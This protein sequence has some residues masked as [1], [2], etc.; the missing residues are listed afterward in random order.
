MSD[1]P[2]RQYKRKKHSAEAVAVATAI[3]EAVSQVQESDGSEPVEVVAEVPMALYRAPVAVPAAQ[4]AHQRTV[5]I[6][7][8][9][10]VRGVY[11]NFRYAIE[12]GQ[13][14]TLPEPVA[15]WLV[16]VGRAV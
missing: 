2:T 3:A 16:S 12:A 1:T 13:V 5:N 9:E 10:T 7:A 14:Y 6:K 8:T 11:G 4:A 15:A